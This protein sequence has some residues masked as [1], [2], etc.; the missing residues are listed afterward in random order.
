M[1]AA[2]EASAGVVS[3]GKFYVIG[4]DDLA[5]ALGSNY[6]YDIASNTWTTGAPL[7][8][9]RTNLNGTASGGLVYVYGGEDAAF[10]AMNTLYSYNPATNTW[11]TLAPNPG[12]ANEGNYAP[13]TTYGAGKLITAGGSDG[14]FV[15]HT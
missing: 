8:D 10:A 1:P 2:L 3:G 14:S 13:I 7:P 5:N 15:P 9:V 6:I 11:A 4:G 12:G